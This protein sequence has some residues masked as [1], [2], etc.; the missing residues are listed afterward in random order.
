MNTKKQTQMAT[1]T[2]SFA[3]SIDNGSKSSMLFSDKSTE[4]E[5]NSLSITQGRQ[6]LSLTDLQEKS[7]KLIPPRYREYTDLAAKVLR[8]FQ[9]ELLIILPTPIGK[10]SLF[11]DSLELRNIFHSEHRKTSLD[12]HL[13]NLR[14]DFIASGGLM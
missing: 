9:Q 12:V 13:G 5:K 2:V 10:A 1:N 3:T 6:C 14:F 4:P 7:G 11:L 8:K